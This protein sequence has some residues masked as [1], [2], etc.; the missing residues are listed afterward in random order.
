MRDHDEV[1][2]RATDAEPIYNAVNY[3]LIDRYYRHTER[4]NANFQS[5]VGEGIWD[6]LGVRVNRGA[7]AEIARG[8]IKFRDNNPCSFCSIQFG[9]M[10]RNSVSSPGQAW[11]TLERATAHGFDYIYLTADDLPFTFGKLLRAMSDN[12]PDWMANSAQSAEPVIAGYARAD[13]LAY[14]DNAELLRKIGIKVL[15]VG[16]DAA[17][18]FSL[19]AMNKPLKV[20]SETGGISALLR[21]GERM[22]ESNKLAL[23]RAIEEGLRLRLGIVLG[24]WE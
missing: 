23:Q 9:G 17:N 11:K 21:T 22:Y 14:G 4:Y 13:G 24:I 15:M 7:P 2:C 20:L 18:P 3:D 8:C 1:Y 5:R 12:V 16:L 6:A 19:V 10:W